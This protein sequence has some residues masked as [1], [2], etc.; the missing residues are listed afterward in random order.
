MP[1]IFWAVST[2][3][4]APMAILCP[5]YL[6]GEEEVRAGRPALAFCDKDNAKSE[7]LLGTVQALRPGKNPT[8]RPH[9]KADVCFLGPQ[10]AKD[11]LGQEP[12]PWE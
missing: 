2:T 5:L 8:K 7:P 4:W 11:P 6:A 12:L 1:G 10:S 3:A 9:P